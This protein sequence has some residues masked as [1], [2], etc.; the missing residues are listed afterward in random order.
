METYKS[1]PTIPP[2]LSTLVG[3][4]GRD[5]GLPGDQVSQA[6]G[7]TLNEVCA[8]RDEYFRDDMNSPAGLLLGQ[9]CLV[10]DRIRHGIPS[11]R[12]NFISLL[13]VAGLAEQETVEVEA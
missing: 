3:P 11:G 13:R 6:L 9:V 1:F 5:G 2:A 8:L 7:E 12:E 10:L 4:G